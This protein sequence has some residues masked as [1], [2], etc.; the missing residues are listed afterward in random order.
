M[1]KTVEPSIIVTE[2][3]LT[4]GIR[5]VKKYK[6]EDCKCSDVNASLV[7]GTKCFIEINYNDV[8]VK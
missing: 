3:G 4:S 8:L 1:K 7:K 2:K 6:H 5:L